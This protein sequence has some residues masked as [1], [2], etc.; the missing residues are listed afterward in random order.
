MKIWTTQTG[1]EIP[2]KKL[3][4]SHLLNILNYVKKVAKKL[5]G[6]YIDGGCGWDI[7]DAWAITG[8][9]KDWLD[10]FDYKGLLKEAKKRNLIYY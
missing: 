8:N 10:K 2:Y 6:E 1:E 9:E 4:D 3:G 5:D 7:E